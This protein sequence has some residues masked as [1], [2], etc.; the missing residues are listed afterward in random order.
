MKESQRKQQEKDRIEKWKMIELT[1]DTYAHRKR[2]KERG[3]REGEKKKRQ[4]EKK[5]K[6]KE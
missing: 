3:G 5:K 1:A 6:K 4:S 2:E